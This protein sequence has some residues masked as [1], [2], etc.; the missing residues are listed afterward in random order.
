MKLRALTLA[1][2]VALAGC[3]PSSKEDMVAK[4]R[5]VRA[6]SSSVPSASP[7]TSAS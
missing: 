3:G 2:V 4:A 1:L 6:L 7:T 5:E